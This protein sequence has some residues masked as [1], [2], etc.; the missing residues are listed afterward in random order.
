ME[1]WHAI[2]LS[3]IEGITEFLP[4]SSTGHMIIGS[5]LMGINDDAFVK[6]FTVIVQFG[7]ILSILVLYWKRFFIGWNAQKIQF[8]LK[9][10]I[11]F[12]PA[13]VIGLATIHIVDRLLGSA[14]T[15]AISFILGGIVLIF[16]DK[17]FEKTES[18]PVTIDTITYKN[19]LL[20]GFFQCLALCPGVSRSGATILG[21]L[22]QKFNRKLAT[23]FS[24]FLAV[25][26]LTAAT[27][28]K[29]FKIYKTIEPQQITILLVGNVIAF[30]VALIAIKAF[31]GIVSRGGFKY[32]GYYRII[33]GIV[34]LVMLYSGYQMHDL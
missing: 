29:V 34:I 8:Y 4:I 2:V 21:A 5:S 18:S 15:V 27:L 11:A 20:I 13:A 25:P 6:N 14:V 3:I 17:W 23:E 31:I 32:F 12:L 28:Y 24:F 7:A 9:L 26:T 30:I 10:F 16:A 1:M 19:V 33:V 22:T